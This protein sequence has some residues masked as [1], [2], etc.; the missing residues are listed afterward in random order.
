MLRKLAILAV[1]ASAI[2]QSSTSYAWC[3]LFGRRACAPC[4]SR[5]YSS[6]GRSYSTCESCYAYAPTYSTFS[7]ATCGSCYNGKCVAGNCGSQ[8][9]TN[10]S[11]RIEDAPKPC[12]PLPEELDNVTKESLEQPTCTTPS[13]TSFP[14][15]S[16]TCSTETCPSCRL[17]DLAKQPLK[18]VAES[19]Y[20]A[21]VN[22]IRRQYGVRSLT[23]D[24]YLEQGC[25]AH[26]NF[27]ARYRV[28]QHAS[29]GYG[30]GEIIAQNYSVGIETALNQWLNSPAHRSILLSPNAVSCGVAAKRDGYGCNWCVMRF[31]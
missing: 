18:T 19:V 4:A 31:N 16:P 12:G 26:A 13:K 20:L 10:G 6:C 23:L 30:R 7:P 17:A 24:A 15:A 25:E 22:S 8:T 9:C 5:C 2:F 11:C 29:S 21:R 14:E 27:M 1:I 28:L 3:G